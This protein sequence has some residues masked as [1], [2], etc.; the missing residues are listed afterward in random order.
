MS[1]KYILPLILILNGFLYSQNYH[2]TQGKLEIASSGQANYSLPIALPPS[3]QNVGPTINLVYSSGQ[4]GGVAG[5]GWSINSLSSINRI[6]SRKDLDGLVDGVDF[7]DNDKLALD[8]QR[9]LIKTGNYWEDGSTYE[10]EVQS[11]TKVELVVIG[12]F[13]TFVVTAVD[14]SISYYNNYLNQT[15][16]L[17]TFY[18]TKF[19][20]TKG[21]IIT[22]SYQHEVYGLNANPPILA[23]FYIHEIKFSSNIHG[24]PTP[25]NKINFTYKLAERIEKNYIKGVQ[26]RKSQILEKIEVFTSDLLFKKYQITHFPADSQGYERVKKLQEFNGNNEAA[27]PVIFEYFTTSYDIDTNENYPPTTP[28]NLENISLT[29]DFDGDSKIDFLLENKLGTKMF[30]NTGTY[31]TLPFIENKRTTFIGVSLTNNKL[32]QKQSIFNTSES[33]NN[34]EFKLYNLNNS[35]VTLDNT[36]TITFDNSRG[37]VNG[38]EQNN[39]FNCPTVPEIKASN[40]YLEGDFNGDGLSEV[41][42]FSY[43]D[44]N[45][46]GQVYVENNKNSNLVAGGNLPDNPNP[47]ILQ[48][49]ITPNFKEIRL[50][51]LNP[52][53]SSEEN[54]AGNCNL[55]TS[56]L[57]LQGKKRIVSDF[58]GDGKADILVLKD[59]Q[60]YRVL[61]FKQ[62]IVAPWIQIEI[63]G[64]GYIDSYS[65]TKTILF[66]DY[67]GDG[68]T[69]IMLPE[70][71]GNGCEDLTNCSLWNIYYSNPKL[72]SLNLFNKESH[73]ITPYMPMYDYGNSMQ[74]YRNQYITIDVNK[75]GKSDLV[76]IQYRRFDNSDF[77]HHTN[78][79]INWDFFVYIN[80]LGKRIQSNFKLEYTS[81]I[82]NLDLADIP[83][84]ISSNYKFKGIN[85]DFMVVQQHNLGTNGCYKAVKFIGFNK[86]FAKENLIKKIIQSEGSIVDEI[87][88]APMVVE[89][90]EHDELSNFYSSRNSLNYPL[91]ELKSLPSLILVSKLLN[92]TNGITKFQE[93]KYHGFSVHIGGLGTLGFNKTARTSWCINDKDSKNWTITENDASKRGATINT[94]IQH[95]DNDVNFSFS[96]NSNYSNL[97][98][99]VENEFTENLDSNTHLYS[100]LLNKQ[101][102]TDYLTNVISK[103]EYTYSPNYFLP[104]KVV[105]KNYTG[106]I[107]EGTFTTTTSFNNSL[108]NNDYYIG[109][110]WKVITKSEAY[111]DVKESTEIL[112]YSGVN[113][114]KIEKRVLNEPETLVEE[115]NYYSNNNLKSKT[116]SVLNSVVPVNP[117]NVEHYEYDPTSRFVY[118]ST[119]INNLETTNE[120]YHPLYGVVL[121]QTNPYGFSTISQYD[122]FGKRT[123]VKDILNIVTTYSYSRINGIYKTVQKRA[124]DNENFDGSYSIVE[125]D[126][127]GNEIRKG[128]KN[129]NGVM[130][131]LNTEYDEYGRKYKVSE[132]YFEN[133]SP[134]QWTT[135]QYDEYSRPVVVNSYNGKTT[136]ISY[137]GLTVASTDGLLNKIVTKNS[138]G[139]VM[140][141]IDNSG[142][143]DG[144]LN[145]TYNANGN[146]IKSNFNGIEILT[147]FN[148]WGK[149][150][151][152]NDP[153]AGIYSYTYNGFGETLSETTPK[154]TTSYEI[155]QVGKLTKKTI[156]GLDYSD[157]TNIES[158]YIYDNAL[159]TN[160]IVNNPND[161]NSSYTYYY[162][163]FK[164]IETTIEELPE[165]T[166]TNTI[167]FDSFGRVAT[168]TN[169]AVSHGETASSLIQNE[170]SINNGDLYKITDPVNDNILWQTN[171]I[172]ARGQLLKANLGNGID[173][174]NSYDAFGYPTQ[175]S[176][177]LGL[178]DIMTLNNTYIPD[179][180]N[181]KT[182]YNSMFNYFEKFEYDSLDRLT[183]TDS[184]GT[185]ILNAT[186][187]NSTE[188]FIYFGVSNG[189]ITLQNQK[190]NVI[191]PASFAG[192]KKSIYLNATVGKT[193][194]ITGNANQISGGG[195]IM[196]YIRE[197]EAS[198]QFIINETPIQIVGSGDFDFTYTTLSDSDVYLYFEI[199]EGSNF[200]PGPNNSATFTLDNIKVDLL[201]NET[202]NY[203]VEGR[204]TSNTNIGNYSYDA[205][206]PFQ[207]NSI[208]NITGET[209]TYFA[210]NH[211]LIISYNA[212]K[213]PIQIENQGVE[214]IS[215]GYNA[216]Q[217]R[218]VMYYGSAHNNKLQ[219]PFQKYYSGDGSMEIKYTISNGEIEF[220]TYVGG[221]AYT[222]PILIKS[223]GGSN[224]EYYY[225]HRD[226]QGS[227]LAI[228]NN[229]GHVVEKRLFDAWG[230]ILKIQT[231]DGTTLPIFKFFDRGYTGHE[232]LQGVGLIN[233]NARL[234]DPKVHRFLQPDTYIQDPYNTQNYNRYSYCVNNPLKYTDITGNVF[235]IDDA[236]FI[237]IGLA[238]ASYLIS[239]AL[240]NTPLKFDGLLSSIVVGTISSIATFGVGEMAST[241]GNLFVRSSFQALAHGFVQGGLG[242]IQGGNFWTGFASGSLSSIAASGWQ[243]IGGK[244]SSSGVGTIAFGTIS[245][246]AG[247][248]LTGGNFWQGAV[249]GMV[250]SGLNHVAHEVKIRKDLVTRMKKGNI[251]P[252]GKPDFSDSG[253]DKMNKGVEGLEEDYI[254]GGSPKVSFDS[255]D[256]K[257]GGHTD[258]GHV[259]LNKSNITTNYRY[260]SVLFHEYR[261]AWQWIYK[262]DGWMSKYSNN[263]DIAYNLMERDAYG[264][265]IQIGIYSPFDT[266]DSIIKE[267]FDLYRNLTKFIKHF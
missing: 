63:L 265:T 183:T 52:N 141:S 67:N 158:N 186:F 188:G 43:F 208:T 231:G 142:E 50:V 36:K 160:I 247:A 116:I 121:N 261:H 97:I 112:H 119:D 191:A 73:N 253:I 71:D 46:Y 69:D 10:T 125:Q 15:V 14:G 255:T 22:Y 88:Y 137:N 199:E 74:L 190:L 136:K 35:S 19:Q 185:L 105:T 51:D 84:A 153:S 82:F 254:A 263:A 223:K 250:V 12:G 47:C 146:L 78:Y 237:G 244:F 6:A 38:C 258:A 90:N 219:R 212:F 200:Q 113:V 29:G 218:S 162:D 23:P 120:S 203:D 41:M 70:V 139:H 246:A 81:P 118:K 166:F 91:L 207:A 94:F 100:I 251:N 217:Q 129:I 93:F 209:N 65:P 80:N 53:V 193:M 159:L 130:T 8:G 262:Y 213:A 145:F 39:Y 259:H 98:S 248:A 92:T 241:I 182:R 149:K 267:N 138:N 134:N 13:T 229:G 252:A 187:T 220:I 238:V 4:Q 95:L 37:C 86:N 192:T 2:D 148:N 140:T 156:I 40:E 48:H 59:D 26:L 77:W 126:V 104:E 144:I 107:L 128:S 42:I 60:S 235:G 228:T 54:T 122:N 61:S 83:F 30:E 176:H 109:R 170:Y 196:A 233:M 58:N 57:L 184:S 157:V 243:K 245:G 198:T 197:F 205:Q 165:A 110:P 79:D 172:N 230:N 103:K 264:Y 102:T 124:D 127:L 25:L 18:I 114:N 222:A 211:D 131:F 249:I 111:G 236:I 115:Y 226:Q 177:G 117:R 27:N 169:T 44:Y 195:V 24:N 87:N 28:E 242:N 221:D 76:R 66:G 189:S 132:P 215:F 210:T 216:M 174:A 7:D 101:T 154:G 173:I 260:A 45:F 75:D 256:P 143:G 161:G 163:S 123:S 96:V 32:N 68:K 224:K 56:S 64:E 232:H 257:E 85:T 167:T 194:R 175:I 240:N 62:L 227:I 31:Y 239:S 214:K 106:T 89:N 49:I 155:D 9:L 11:N 34:I 72:N 5:Q 179:R 21:N 204:I 99:R 133:E 33:L 151:S 202:Q 234:Y 206:H 178:N 201:Q 108:I 20:D 180:G 181:L 171:T 168:E 3:I 150:T 147:I 16:D 1:N 152:I 164:R 135:T 225:L 55:D 17:T 266:G